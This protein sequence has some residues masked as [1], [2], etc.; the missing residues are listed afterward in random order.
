VLLIVFA[1]TTAT[2]ALWAE[3]QALFIQMF[4]PTKPSCVYWHFS[5]SMPA[6]MCHL[7][8]A[9]GRRSDSKP[10][11]APAGQT[12]ADRGASVGNWTLPTGW[13]RLKG[14]DTWRTAL[15]TGLK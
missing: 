10:G 7:L 14:D 13:S 3:S 2:A 12:K 11:V 15:T 5:P 4:K 8:T 6:L 9:L 1:A